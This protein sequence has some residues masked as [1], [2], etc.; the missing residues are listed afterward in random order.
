MQKY[1]RNLSPFVLINSNGDG[2]ITV[3]FNESEHPRK[4]NGEFT[5]KGKEELSRVTEDEYSQKR[6]WEGD[7]N[8]PKTSKPYAQGFNRPNTKSHL[9]HAKEMGLSEKQ[10]I[11]KAVDFFN[12]AEG[13]LYRASNG[14][15]FKYDAKHNIVCVCNQDGTIHTFYKNKTKNAFHRTIQQEKLEEIT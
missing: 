14:K 2:R 6:K 3:A 10:Y 11:K 13:K 7:S 4:D 5:T 9:A 15:Y 12:S 1:T 8:A